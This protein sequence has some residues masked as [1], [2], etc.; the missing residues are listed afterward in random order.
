MKDVTAIGHEGFSFLKPKDTQPEVM[1]PKTG[2]P[3]DLTDPEYPVIN[4]PSHKFKWEYW[5]MPKSVPALMENYL[6]ER[7]TYFNKTRFGGRLR[8]P[9][10]VLLRDVNALRMKLRGLW[11]SSVS[12]PPGKLSISPNLFNA[13]HEGW[14]NRTLIH[15]M[16]HQEEWET[17]G[18]IDPKE[19]GHGPR[20]R[21]L[22]TRAGL[23]PNRFDT[24]RN[25][26]YADKKEKK[27]YQEVLEKNKVF[28]QNLEIL[29]GTRSPMMKPAEGL[30]VLFATSKGIIFGTLMSKAEKAGHWNVE[31]PAD[32]AGITLTWHVKKTAFYIPT[33]KDKTQ[34]RYEA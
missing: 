3:F 15:E 26:T 9:E 5:K 24:E 30:E 27:I 12:K 20:W 8:K 31:E 32:V 16:C 21:A 4:D 6:E 28:L 11:T 2:K 22:M 23:H 18:S 25:E 19:K 13:P 10:L 17:F 14:V 34:K 7:W 33:F 1:D 29:R